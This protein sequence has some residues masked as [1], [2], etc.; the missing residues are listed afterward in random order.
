[1]L[2]EIDNLSCGYKGTPIVQN[3][4][5]SVTDGEVVCLLGPNGVGKTTFFKTAQGFLPAITGKVTIEGKSILELNRRD[6]AKRIAY[7][8]QIRGT[9]F[10]VSCWIWW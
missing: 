10:H 1:M 6:L 2:F 7:V 9:P 5:F 4:N 8:P 3:I